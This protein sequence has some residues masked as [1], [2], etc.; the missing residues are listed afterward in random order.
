MAISC[1]VTYSLPSRPVKVSQTT[2][3]KLVENLK[4][5]HPPTL[6]C[7]GH[8][9]CF[10]PSVTFIQIQV[11][12]LLLMGGTQHKYPSGIQARLLAW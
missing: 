6:I 1:C 5:L 3:D 10:P 7:V 4:N 8:F 2:L 11:A 12:A 9:L